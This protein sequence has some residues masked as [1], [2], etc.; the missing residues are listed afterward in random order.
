MNAGRTLARDADMDIGLAQRPADRATGTASLAVLL[1]DRAACTLSAGATCQR[2]H[3][4]FALVCGKHRGKHCCRLAAGA[5]AQQ[6]ITG[7]TECAHLAREHVALQCIGAVG[8]RVGH[9]GNQRQCSKLG[10]FTLETTDKMR[11]ELLGQNA[12]DAR[13][14]GQNLAAAGDARKHCLHGLREGLAEHR[15]GLVLEV[16]AVDEVL[17]YPL[18]KHGARSYRR[19]L[20]QDVSPRVES[21]FEPLDAL[22]LLDQH[23]IETAWRQRAQLHQIV[24]RGKDDAALLDAGDA[25]AGT[26]VT[27]A[28]ALSDFDKHQ[29]R[30]AWVAHDQ[31]DLATA[32]AGRSIIALHQRQTLRLKMRQR[33]VLGR[34]AAGLG[35][36]RR[37][38]FV[39]LE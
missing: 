28:G 35:G 11:G 5:E 13:A 20:Q 38:L 23:H 7:L 21:G 32:P 34:I 33:V 22:A 31:V 6:H 16:C 26:A 9:I 24:P 3:R 19:G 8:G 29:R 17:L 12:R 1:D 25:A 36:G 37:T 10:P 27:G 39:V 30:I 2:H 18:L 14:T 4:H 15:S